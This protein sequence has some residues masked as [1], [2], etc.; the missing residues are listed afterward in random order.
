MFFN[1]IKNLFYQGNGGGFQ[2]PTTSRDDFFAKLRD[3]DNCDKV[4]MWKFHLMLIMGDIAIQRLPMDD[5]T[6]F[7]FDDFFEHMD[8]VDM[9]ECWE[10]N[11]EMSCAALNDEYAYRHAHAIITSLVGLFVSYTGHEIANGYPLCKSSEKNKKAFFTMVMKMIDIVGASVIAI[12]P[13]GLSDD[14]KISLIVFYA[15]ACAMERRK[16]MNDIQCVLSML[17]ECMLALGGLNF[18]VSHELFDYSHVYGPNP[19]CCLRHLTRPGSKSF[20]KQDFETNNVYHK[21]SFVFDKVLGALEK[22][23]AAAEKKAEV[24]GRRMAEKKA[25]ALGRRM[26]AEEAKLKRKKKRRQKVAKMRKKALVE[27]CK[28]KQGEKTKQVCTNVKKILY[29]EPKLET[30]IPEKMDAYRLRRYY[31]K[32]EKE[33]DERRLMRKMLEQAHVLSPS[34]KR[35]EKIHRRERQEYTHAVWREQKCKHKKARK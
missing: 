23:K 22:E 12:G 3:Q 17:S 20:D 7:S 14:M 5:G 26:A 29:R 34:R 4:A 31:E 24:L 25:E 16:T 10:V 30:V 19:Y 9:L 32:V 33:Q 6:M 28:K 8:K 21:V 13:E 18:C 11:L 1:K 35:E 15:Y 2:T 27:L